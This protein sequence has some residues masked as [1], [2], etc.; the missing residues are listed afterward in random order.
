MRKLETPEQI[1]ARVGWMVQLVG[2]SDHAPSFAYTIGLTDRHL[3][4]LI[5]FS[6]PFEV[7]G[8]ALNT[9][10]Q[11]MSDGEVLPGH[12]RLQDVLAADVQLVQAER[13][14]ADQFMFQALYRNPN[15]RALQVV[16]PDPQSG[17][18]PWED[19]YQ[20]RYRSAQ[21]LLLPTLQ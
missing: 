2:A 1:I 16:W 20:E 10:A 5:T 4:E 17:A 18:F 6:L 9:L 11:R 3:P 19:G 15:Y 21:P 14:M 7:A 12:T 13:A 8:F